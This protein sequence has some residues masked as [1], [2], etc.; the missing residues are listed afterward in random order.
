MNLNDENQDFFDQIK[1]CTECGN[2]LDPTD[3]FCTN[4]GT[5]LSHM[6]KVNLKDSPESD[7]FSNNS[8]INNDITN[9]SAEKPTISENQYTHSENKSAEGTAKH[10]ISSAEFAFETSEYG[11]QELNTAEAVSY[12]SYPKTNYYGEY[13][14]VKKKNPKFKKTLLIASTV[15]FA[16]VFVTAGVLYLAGR[17]N[18]KAA[19]DLTAKG[20]DALPSYC[21]PILNN[22]RIEKITYDKAKDT[23]KAGY[24]FATV[25][26]TVQFFEADLKKA[27]S[28]SQPEE[29]IKSVLSDIHKTEEKSITLNVSINKKEKDFIWE[30]ETLDRFYEQVRIAG[31]DLAKNYAGYEDIDKAVRDLL[32]PYP[33]KES[34]SGYKDETYYTDEYKAYLQD[35]TAYFAKDGLK[36]NGTVSKDAEVIYQC[37]SERLTPYL[38]SA[39]NPITAL[40]TKNDSI[41]TLTFDYMSGTAILSE[42]SN[43]IYQTEWNLNS[44]TRPTIDNLDDRLLEELQK[45]SDSFITNKSNALKTEECIFNLNELV[46]LS[47][48]SNA[49]VTAFAQKAVDSYDEQLVALKNKIDL[50][51]IVADLPQTGVLSGSGSGPSIDISTQSGDGAHYIKVERINSSLSENGTEVMTVFI[52]DG[53]STT[54]RL[55]SGNYKFKYAIG[56]TWYG[57]TDKFGPEGR[58]VMADQVIN[59]ESGYVYTL[60]LYDVVDGNLGSK[61]IDS[62]DF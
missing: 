47:A 35:L 10:E 55:P 28:G 57:T 1:F 16:V 40:N 42:A 13:N 3:L 29:Y 25:E 45:A 39:Y 30:T 23:G 19:A 50:M 51:L 22:I 38:Y 9:D 18:N 37:L 2:T 4:C 34:G 32:F 6:M 36:I 20:M 44:K 14:A 41:Y 11:E 56:H 7:S 27:Y 21:D 5:K 43:S 26:A 54:I 12:A 33:F 62:G 49:Q 15:L 46:G 58:Y 53:E 59:V 52:R 24:V 48:S 60:K 61:N 8:N 31:Q 17:T